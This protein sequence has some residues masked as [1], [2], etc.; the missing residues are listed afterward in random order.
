MTQRIVNLNIDPFIEIF[1]LVIS[2]V[3]DVVGIIAIDD[4]LGRRSDTWSLR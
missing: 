3:N 2:P 4:L 1:F